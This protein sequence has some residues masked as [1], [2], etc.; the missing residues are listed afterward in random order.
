V[1]GHGSETYRTAGHMARRVTWFLAIGA[2]VAGCQSADET[3]PVKTSSATAPASGTADADQLAAATATAADDVTSA[4]ASA[5]VAAEFNPPFPNRTEL[6][7]P[8]H[9][10]QGTIR[11]DDEHGETIELK[12]FMNVN[13]PQVVLAIDGVISP[14]PEGGEKYGVRVISI[15]PPSVVL[16]RG[17]NR[18]TATLD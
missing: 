15:H 12:G 14:I 1:T 16:Q 10:G 9:G 7:E 3:A 17:R 18:W 6:F 5:P 13:G 4:A 8:P 11:R 2:L